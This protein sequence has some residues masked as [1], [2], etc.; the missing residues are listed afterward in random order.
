MFRIQVLLA[1]PT[2]VLRNRLDDVKRSIT[3]GGD[4]WWQT[5]A[6]VISFRVTATRQPAGFLSGRLLQAASDGDATGIAAYLYDFSRGVVGESDSPPPA[7]HFTRQ[8]T[9]RP[10]C[11]PSVVQ[12]AVRGWPGEQGAAG[13]PGALIDDAPSPATRRTPNPSGAAA[14]PTNPAGLV[15]SGAGAAR[16]THA[17]VRARCHAPSPVGRRRPCCSPTFAFGPGGGPSPPDSGILACPLGPRASSQESAACEG[18]RSVATL[19]PRTSLPADRSRG[20]PTGR[21]PVRTPPVGV[22]P[23]SSSGRGQRFLVFRID[24]AQRAHQRRPPRRSSATLVARTGGG[25]R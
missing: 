16:A 24:P 9:P 18:R 6:G 4:V 23:P 12:A 20:P 3:R 10:L 11:L 17:V 7:A 14:A 8:Y 25:A 5:H 2:L 1:H 13:R 19:S 22:P 21:A 15:V